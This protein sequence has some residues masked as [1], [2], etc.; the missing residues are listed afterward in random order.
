[1]QKNIND[2]KFKKQN[3]SKLVSRKN[4]NKNSNL[5]K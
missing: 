2:E 5:W 4:Q 3:K 1:M